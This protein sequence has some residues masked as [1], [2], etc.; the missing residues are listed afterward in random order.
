MQIHIPY[1]KKE[2][3]IGIYENYDFKESQEQG[4]IVTFHHDPEMIITASNGKRVPI[5]KKDLRMN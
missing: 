3:V 2:K 1:I 4:K 5:N